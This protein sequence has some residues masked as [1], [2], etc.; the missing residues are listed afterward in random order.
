MGVWGFDPGFYA[1][2]GIG[3]SMSLCFRAWAFGSRSM[4]L[5]L[6]L[7][8]LVLRQGLELG[9]TTSRAGFQDYR[10]WGDEVPAKVYGPACIRQV[11]PGGR[12]LQTDSNPEGV[13]FWLM[14]GQRVQSLELHHPWVT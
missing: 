3:C 6:R 11:R 5:G 9:L 2:L 1:G 12:G 8:G 13:P 10:T 7:S 14:G 4:C